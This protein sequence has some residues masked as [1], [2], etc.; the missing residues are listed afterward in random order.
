MSVLIGPGGR[1]FTAEQSDAIRA[2]SGSLL[3]EANAGSGKTSVLV[4]RFVRS[5][6]EDGVRPP[7]ILA[8]TFTDR[9]AG[10][11]RARVRERF[12]ELGRRDEAR[13]TE[14]AWVSTIHGFCA[15]VLRAHAIA[16]GLDPAF[17]VLDEAAARTLRDLAWD[18]ALADW[19]DGEHGEAALDIVAAYDTDRLRKMIATVHDAL[20]SDGQTHPVLPRAPGAAEPGA[21][22]EAL[23]SAASVAARELALAGAGKRVGEA[24]AKVARCVEL[25]A[26]APAGPSAPPHETSAAARGASA[27]A[28]SA[29]VLA[30]LRFGAA[31]NAL[32]TEACTRYLAALAAYAG[33]CRDRAAGAAVARLD[34][35]LRGYAAAY[36]E[37]KRERAALDF[38]DLELFT[39]DLLHAEPALRRS[40]AERFDRVM[41]DEFQ[42]S[43]GRQIAL[44]EA[45][46]RDD[47][48]VVGDEQQSIYGFRNADVEVFRARRAALA[49]TGRVATLA[50]N[51]RS[52]GTILETINAAFGPRL[53]PDFVALREGREWSHDGAAAQPLVELLLTD[54][55]GWDADDAPDLG[56]LPR[57]QPWRHAEAR[58]L[59]QRIRDLVDAGD[60]RPEE[61]VVLLRG[62]GDLPVYE[63][64]LEDQD[65]L[66]LSVG[67]RGY[68]GRQVVRDLCAWLAALANPRDETALYGVLASPLVG[69]SSDALAHIARAGR[70]NAWRA[71]ADACEG[72]AAEG[73]GSKRPSGGRF[74]PD[75]LSDGDALLA[76]MRAGGDDGLLARLRGGDRER[77]AVFAERFAA[78][79]AL[80]PRLGLDELLRRVVDAT[81]YDL[82]VLSLSGGARRL[83]NVHKLLRLA[84][85]FERESGRDVRGLA[86]L[87]TAE[88]EA[89]ARETDAPVEL[90]DVKAVRLMSI[91]AAKGLEFPTVV[92]ADLGRR[93]P[94][95]E[96]DLL[97]D[98]DEI[99]LRLVGLDGSSERA[100]HYERLRDRVRERSAAE[101][102]RVLYVAVTR[103]C[104]R[105]ILCGGVA[106]DAWPKDSPG[107]SPLSW[108][109]P[110]L[111]G[112]D[113]GRLPT[114]AEPVKDVRWSDG[115]NTAVVHCEL[116]APGTVGVVLRAGSLAPAGASLPLAPAQPPRPAQPPPPALPPRVRTLSYSRLAAWNACGYRYYLQRVLRLPEEPVIRVAAAAGADGAQ[117]TLDPRVRGT[118]V[119]AVLERAGGTPSGRA[120][121]RAGRA[122]PAG[123]GVAPGGAVPAGGE[124]A[125]SG[126]ASAGDGVAPGGAVPAGGEAATSGAASARD[127]V[128]GGGASAEG[129]AAPAERLLVVADVAAEHGIALTEAETADVA[130]LADAFAQSPLA[131]R[132]AKARSVQREHAFAVPLGDTLLTG[133]VDVLAR[134][135]GSAQLVV[136]YKSDALKPDADLVA[137]A[138]ERYGVQ[139]RVYA[140]AALRGGAARVEV[141]YAF[142]ERP[143]ELV[144]TR[145]AASDADLLERELLEL[146][147]GMLAGEYPV[148]ANPHRELCE[149]CP[150]RRALCSYLEEITLAEQPRP[151]AKVGG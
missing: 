13:E 151:A 35:L 149:T 123:D 64:A 56:E 57:S 97:V 101:E 53:G 73:C 14:T 32:R 111:L 23:A 12:V 1:A 93:R 87:A 94:G 70:G 75:A 45:L 110:A 140:L 11:L 19:L 89:E 144:I 6:I 42:D 139:R 37:A 52:R 69:L 81:G 49:A 92:V 17:S 90:G 113:L 29:A 85:A 147:A 103:A 3:L 33:A 31:A 136:D 127:A 83:A 82:H 61:I 65:L 67:G 59:A 150:G 125:T 77:L 34:A 28:P 121:A 15:R 112:G 106:V 62:L 95:D 22:R 36:A 132:L 138:D 107:A 41:V 78:E 104:E 105:L 68:W 134:E 76:R 146:A 24:R 66:T 30:E 40:Y 135:R 44:F 88:L 118:L 96:D 141:A 130:R 102:D 99:G 43:N 120:A 16:A 25:L 143:A 48:F 54:Q 84:A 4:E 98:G 60:A 122:A 50:T 80:A 7:R 79:R 2:R 131:A 27:G 8:I 142:L 71:I 116:N 119:H 39:R 51:F 10:E 55:A 74:E 18:R 115:A 91:H 126:A 109:G 86:D 108:L 124:A 26:L 133:V 47:L 38:D 63:R 21:L 72:A 117:P 100:L 46:D 114:A 20:R 148:T 5:V 137:Y 145:Y 128:A 129:G 58:L 9:A